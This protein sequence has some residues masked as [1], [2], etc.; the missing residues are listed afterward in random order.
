MMN[1]SLPRAGAVKTCCARSTLTCVRSA[2]RAPRAS[3]ALPGILVA[4]IAALAVGCAKPGG[5]L[6]AVSFADPYF[7]ETSTFELIDCTYRVDPGGDIHI[8]GH[9][10]PGPDDSRLDA[11]LHIHVYWKPKP[12]KTP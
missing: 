6:R 7:P 5:H 10:K 1:R 3:A 4:A 9:A 12:G 2:A 8:A 11:W